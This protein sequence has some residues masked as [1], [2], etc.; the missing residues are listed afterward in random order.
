[1]SIVY[2]LCDNITLHAII[3]N[4]SMQ[5]LISI[6]ETRSLKIAVAQRGA[7]VQ[8]LFRKHG[9]KYSP[10]LSSRQSAADPLL[11]YS[12]ELKTSPKE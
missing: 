5:Y 7:D 9:Y 3:D 10:K 6:I 1:M 2:V 8:L 12:V 11:D 4:E